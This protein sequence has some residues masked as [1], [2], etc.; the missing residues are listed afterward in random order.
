VRVVA[1]ARGASRVRER[2]RGEEGEREREGKE[3]GNKKNEKN[4]K[5]KRGK[6]EREI[7][8]GKFGDDHGCVGHARRLRAR[9]E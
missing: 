6:R 1:G 8:G 3:K 2:G 4:G 5:R 7:R 9:A